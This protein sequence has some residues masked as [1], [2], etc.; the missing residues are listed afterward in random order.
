LLGYQIWKEDTYR[1]IGVCLDRS[2]VITIRSQCKSKPSTA[3]D[4]AFLNIESL[5]QKIDKLV[6][7]LKAEYDEIKH[8]QIQAL[9]E[10]LDDIN[11]K[12]IEIKD[13]INSI[14][15]AVTSYT[16][17]SLLFST[18]FDVDKYR[19]LPHKITLYSPTFTKGKINGEQLS[20][21]FGTLSLTSL[22]PEKKGYNIKTSQKLHEVGSSAPVKQLLDEPETVTTINTGY[23]YLYNVACFSDEEIWT[24]GDDSTMK[25]F[26]INQGSLLKSITTKSGTTHF[27]IEVTKS[28]DLVYTDYK[29]RTVNI[30]KNEK[31]NVEEMIRLQD[32]KPRAACTTSLDDLLVIMVNDAYKRTNVYYDFSFHRM[33]LSVFFPVWLFA[34]CCLNAGKCLSHQ[35]KKNIHPT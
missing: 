32:W 10:Q 17:S 4:N 1:H 12:I 22:S 26:S 20:E 15:K 3:K 30:A 6:K 2:P 9:Q 8:K 25:L 29:D 34:L 5:G 19:Q 33:L 16:V 31:I 11:K 24:S 27:S 21:L 23:K 13:E 35:L 14:D 7:K 28:G 18:T